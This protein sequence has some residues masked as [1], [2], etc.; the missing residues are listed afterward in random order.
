MSREDI[1]EH[2][3]NSI[4][5]Q[6]KQGTS[7]PQL[8]EYMQNQEPL[9]DPMLCLVH[10]ARVC[11]QSDQS[12]TSGV[13]RREFDKIYRLD[14]HGKKPG[15]WKFLKTF[16]KTKETEI[17]QENFKNSC[18]ESRESALSGSDNQNIILPQG[19]GQGE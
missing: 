14:W 4:I 13:L 12:F 3:D 16:A 18:V 19:E 8:L 6:R 17:T 9:Y 10:V 15:S 5:C 11:N 1:F 7:L 2:I